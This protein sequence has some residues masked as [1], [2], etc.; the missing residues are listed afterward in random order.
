MRE[1]LA[2]LGRSH[3]GRLAIFVLGLAAGFAVVAPGFRSLGNL[4]DLLESHAVL[5][6][7]ASGLLVVLIAGGIAIS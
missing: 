3:E 2:A 1:R 7:M 4:R 5:A 6:I